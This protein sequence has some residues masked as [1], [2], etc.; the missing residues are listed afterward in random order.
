MYRRTYHAAHPLSMAGAGHDDLRDRHL[1]AGRFAAGE[2]GLK[3]TLIRAMGGE[4]IDYTDMDVP[5]V[6]QLK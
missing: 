6:R 4:T 5:D 2:P 3:Q 1:I